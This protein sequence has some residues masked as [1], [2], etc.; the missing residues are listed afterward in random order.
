MFDVINVATGFALG[1]LFSVVFW[2]VTT[3]ILVPK[4]AFSE[5]ISK[6]IMPSGRAVCRIKFC[7]VGPRKIVD[8]QTHI[9]IMVFGLSGSQM[10][11]TIQLKTNVGT[12]PVFG[13]TGNKLAILFEDTVPLEIENKV[14]LSVRKKI[15]ACKTIDDIFSL[16]DDVRYHVAVF[17]YD[18]FSGARK[19]YISKN[20][21]LRDLREGKFIGTG[22]KRGLQMLMHHAEDEH[23]ETGASKQ[24][25]A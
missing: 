11:S 15:E 22:G 8:V 24:V 20:Y 21:T 6:V 17:G 19:V 10:W 23:I 14:S 13:T 4:I 3:H 7:N 16:G 18:Q 5:A 2:Y 12:I 9:R 1:A 25:E